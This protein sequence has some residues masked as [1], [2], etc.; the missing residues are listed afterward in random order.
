[1]EKEEREY[2][3]ITNMR[4]AHAKSMDEFNEALNKNGDE[5]GS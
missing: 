1:M 5:N 3:I 4:S 2:K